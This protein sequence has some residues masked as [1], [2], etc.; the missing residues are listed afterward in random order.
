MSE[1][2]FAPEQAWYFWSHNQWSRREILL[3]EGTAV[4]WR[5]RDTDVQWKHELCTLTDLE[6]WR[7]DG[8]LQRTHPTRPW[9][10]AAEPAP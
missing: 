8:Q 10:A 2:S 3:V 5:Y 9:S 1:P 6:R 7:A 4:V